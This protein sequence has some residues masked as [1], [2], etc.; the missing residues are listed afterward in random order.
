M[1]DRRLAQ[2]VP[3]ELSIVVSMLVDKP[4]GEDEA[5]RIDLICPLLSGPISILELVTKEEWNGEEAQAGRDH[6]QAA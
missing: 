3:Y 2:A 1:L 6:R 5:C 4:G